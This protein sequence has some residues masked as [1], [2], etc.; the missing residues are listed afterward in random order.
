MQ[1]DF[2]QMGNE[3]EKCF[4]QSVR[5]HVAAGSTE[6]ILVRLNQSGARVRTMFEKH[7]SYMFSDNHESTTRDR[8]T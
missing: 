2:M 3:Y 5:M 8:C 6:V 7:G 1:W 4:V